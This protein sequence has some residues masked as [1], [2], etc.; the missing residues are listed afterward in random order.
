[1]K[2]SLSMKLNLMIVLSTLILLSG[3]SY[4]YVSIFTKGINAQ[5]YEYAR[6]NLRDVTAMLEGRINDLID[7]ADFMTTMPDICQ[8]LSN[9]ANARLKTTSSVQAQLASYVNYKQGVSQM[10]LRSKSGT[11]LRSSAEKPE[12]YTTEFFQLYR[13]IQEEYDLE[14]PFRKAIVTHNYL[15]QDGQR[16]FAL[17]IPVF[18]S[19]AAP[20]DSDFLG[21]LI[22]ICDTNSLLSLIPESTLDKLLIYENDNLL[23]G[24]N[25][26]FLL[27]WN[28]TEQESKVVL[29]GEARTVISSQMK[30]LPWTLYL[31]ALSE[32]V[33]ER[34]EQVGR[35]CLM[36][37]VLILLVQSVLLAL[38]HQSFVQ[39]VLNIVQQMQKI[40]SLSARISLPKNARGEMITLVDEANDMLRRTEQ[41]EK[42]MSETKLR[43]YRERIIF[44]QTQINPHF[45]YNNLQC[46]RGMAA[47]GCMREIREMTSCIASVY[48]YGTRNSAVATLR[49][50]LECLRDYCRIMNL[51]YADKFCISQDCSEETMACELPRMTL[52]PL[53]E[54]SFKHGFGLVDSVGGRVS[55][56][57]WKEENRLIVV[58]QDTGCGMDEATLEHC[59]HSRIVESE[60]IHHLG[61]ANV[62]TRLELLFGTNSSL[63]FR[64]S[65]EGTT[66]TVTIAQKLKK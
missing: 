32:S 43:Y 21:V 34:I 15:M 4:A 53:V 18:R 64:T 49:E 66:V 28:Q 10:Y 20:K 26:S 16:Y 37:A 30:S 24:E 48:R 23:Y 58:I 19:V 5:T 62:R 27:A 47:L 17:L 44:L 60:P 3:L 50:E 33:D 22:A 56:S 12:A 25:D 31:L 39:P 45:L 40:E 54:N 36:I 38:S 41:L 46:I 35:L 42:E 65:S 14:V 29:N 61:V 55:L 52:Q 6:N 57:S 9:D 7:S 1:M 13:K 2:T 51:R 11:R 59:N 63:L 8:F